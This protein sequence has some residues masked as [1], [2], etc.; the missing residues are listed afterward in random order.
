[1]T[2]MMYDFD[3]GYVQVKLNYYS[4]THK[5]YVVKKILINIGHERFVSPASLRS[6][7]RSR[8]LLV[9]CG[10]HGARSKSLHQASNNLSS[11]DFKL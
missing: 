7:R 6:R 3:L 5:I 9:F 1:M 11:T 4:R 8:C 2:Y 10:I